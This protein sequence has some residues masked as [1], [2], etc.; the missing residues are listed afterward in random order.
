MHFTDRSCEKV[1]LNAPSPCAPDRDRRQHDVAGGEEA[2]AARR[3]RRQRD[4]P[5]RRANEQCEPDGDREF[6][7]ASIQRRR[8]PAGFERCQG[9]QDDRRDRE[10]RRDKGQRRDDALRA[11][12]RRRRGPRAPRSS[13]APDPRASASRRTQPLFR[14]G[15][16]ASST[17]AV[18]AA[19]SGIDVCACEPSRRTETPRSA[20]SRLPMA[21]MT[22]T[23]CSECS[24][25]L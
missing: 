21:R 1:E 16:V 25:T 8:R 3:R 9:R 5:Q 20:A 4:L 6:S 7:R 10:A 11:C 2:A 15:G 14:S 13:A 17:K 24:R 12:A 22:G 23:F 18:S 19:S